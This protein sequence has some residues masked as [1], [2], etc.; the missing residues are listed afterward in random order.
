MNTYDTIRFYCPCCKEKNHIFVGHINASNN[1]FQS[2]NIPSL[3][4]SNIKPQ[5]IKC[6]SC[7][8]PLSINL[9]DIP[10]RQYNL[11]VRLDCSGQ[12]GGMEEWYE[13]AIPKYTDEDYD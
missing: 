5:R 3:V 6:K 13:D 4:A 2:T 11:L 7:N 8:R 10:V 9:E 1:F 12:S